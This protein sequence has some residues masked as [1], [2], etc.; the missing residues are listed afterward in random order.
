MSQSFLDKWHPNITKSTLHGDVVLMPC[1]PLQSLLD[2]YR[3]KTIDLWSLDVEGAELEVC[4]PRMQRLS[5]KL[6]Q[7]CCTAVGMNFVVHL[8]CC[9]D[10][11]VTMSLMFEEGNTPERLI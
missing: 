10:H 9:I 4:N 3:M 1:M 11:S 5:V 6:D 8:A 7:S 2:I